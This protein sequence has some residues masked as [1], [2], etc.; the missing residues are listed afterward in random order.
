MTNVISFPKPKEEGYSLVCTI[1][2]EG[3]R[4]FTYS[5]FVDKERLIKDLAG[6]IKALQKSEDE[7]ERC[8]VVNI[9]ATP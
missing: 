2:P 4:I 3:K 9:N 1:S 8:E 5:K 6:I 7:P